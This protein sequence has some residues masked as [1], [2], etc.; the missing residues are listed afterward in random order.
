[1]PDLQEA[2]AELL[3]Q[4]WAIYSDFLPKRT[5]WKEREKKVNLT[6]KKTDRLYLSQVVDTKSDK[7]R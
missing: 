2:E 3:T 4:V 7:A 6:V 5:I 1:M